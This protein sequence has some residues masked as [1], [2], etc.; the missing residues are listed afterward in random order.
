MRSRRPLGVGDES[1]F[2]GRHPQ[3]QPDGDDLER[4]NRHWGRRMN[5]A[6]YTLI[7]CATGLSHGSFELLDIARHRA[8]IGNIASW[9]IINR[10]GKL[11]AWSKPRGRLA[12]KRQA[13][14]ARETQDRSQV[15]ADPPLP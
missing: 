7:D 5:I 6:E 11:V 13:P 15:G 1:Q 2:I 14:N 8:E 4:C 10:D 12:E 9:E 3:D